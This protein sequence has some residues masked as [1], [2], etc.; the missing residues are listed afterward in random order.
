MQSFAWKDITH[1]EVEKDRYFYF[2]TSVLDSS[3][4]YAKYLLETKEV[5]L[6]RLI[7]YLLVLKLVVC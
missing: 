2:T 6:V 4:F 1:W 7:P 3:G 5:R